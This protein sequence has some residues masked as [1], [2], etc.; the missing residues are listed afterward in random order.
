MNKTAIT[1]VLAAALGLLAVPVLAQNT[2]PNGVDQK[3]I[4]EAIQ[5]NDQEIDQA[6]I[7]L[8]S[9]SDASVRLFAQTMIHDHTE[10]NAQLAGAAK[11]LGLDASSPHIVQGMN[12]M[13]SAAPGSGGAMAMSAHAY[14]TQEVTDH[15]NAIGLYKGEAS[16]GSAQTLKTYAADTL[17]ILN[18]H[19]AMA[20]Q[21]LSSGTIT[22]APKQSQ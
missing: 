6:R 20:Q 7:E 14:M 1:T 15:Q 5:A 4:N 11:A 21:Y 2:S 19:L 13:P 22:P 9:T 12:T 8:R 18:Q 17:P 3:F 16:N 10:S